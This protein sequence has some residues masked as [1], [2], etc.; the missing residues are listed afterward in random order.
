MT[1]KTMVQHT[2]DSPS[3][4]CDVEKRYKREYYFVP[5]PAETN[6]LI[7]QTYLLDGANEC[8]NV[9]NG[10][11]A[12]QTFYT[13]HPLLYTPKLTTTKKYLSG[14]KIGLGLT[15]DDGQGGARSTIDGIRRRNVAETVQ[16]PDESFVFV[17]LADLKDSYGCTSA[18][19]SFESE[20]SHVSVS[21]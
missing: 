6:K 12:V 13:K 9:C 14:L 8:F 10:K 1:V 20:S 3:S 15:V 18:A 19:V 7:A 21:R 17:L 4:L 2:G 5:V 16:R 11:E